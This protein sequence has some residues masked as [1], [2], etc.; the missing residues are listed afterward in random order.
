MKDPYVSGFW[1]SVSILGILTASYFYGIRQ[2]HQLNQ[3]VQFLY[4][5]A[6]VTVAVAVV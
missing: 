4:A 1:C 2:A 3:A 6:A 5:A